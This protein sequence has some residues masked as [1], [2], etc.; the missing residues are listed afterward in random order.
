[1]SYSNSLG[2]KCSKLFRICFFVSY[3]FAP[4]FIKHTPQNEL[5]LFYNQFIFIAATFSRKAPQS[6]R[7]DLHH[8]SIIKHK[9]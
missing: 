7:H 6:V 5:A 8:T 9:R 2:L 1:M 4:E 3:I